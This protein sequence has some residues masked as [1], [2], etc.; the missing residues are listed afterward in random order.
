MPKI[1]LPKSDPAN[2][3]SKLPEALQWPAGAAGGLLN[4]LVGGD[5]PT[6]IMPGPSGL[7]S[8]AVS[9]LVTLLSKPQQA[10]NLERILKSVAGTPYEEAVKVAAQ[11]WPR[12]LGHVN[13]VN[14]GEPTF[15]NVLG[16]FTPST[17]ARMGK[18]VG[19]IKLAD[20]P[21]GMLGALKNFLSGGDPADTFGHELTH[22]AQA[23]SKMPDKFF[24]EYHAANQAL[25]YDMNPFEVGARKGGAKLKSLV[26][27]LTGN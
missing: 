2:A 8:Q 21:T 5:D 7:E 24:A 17:Y 12:V 15:Q 18:P 3:A 20:R 16:E 19:D 4:S 6:S 10:A 1:R 26:K 13:S 9:P 22:A 14:V 11:K 25:G 27:K 23:I